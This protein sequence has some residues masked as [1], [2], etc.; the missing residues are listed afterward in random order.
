MKFYFNENRIILIICF[1]HLFFNIT[2]PYV[3]G[4]THLSDSSYIQADVFTSTLNDINLFNLLLF[5]F[6]GDKM[7]TC[8]P[9]QLNKIF[10]F[11]QFSNLCCIPN[12]RTKSYILHNH[13][14]T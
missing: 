2:T 12:A 5:I 6:F 7:N 14:N 10:K 3:V 11:N 13:L 8:V 9:I 1:F 4:G